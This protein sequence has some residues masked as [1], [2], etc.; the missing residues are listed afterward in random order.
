MIEIEQIF[1]RYEADNER[2]SKLLLILHKRFVLHLRRRDI[3]F[4]RKVFELNKESFVVNAKAD[5]LKS[6]W[7][8][9]LHNIKYTIK[10]FFSIEF[11][12]GPVRA[13]NFPIFFVMLWGRC[14]Y[15]KQKMRGEL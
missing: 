2:R 6:I 8:K 10:H 1:R 11:Y 7:K 4:E 5:D 13:Y 9:I 14:I 3:K 15:W 12:N